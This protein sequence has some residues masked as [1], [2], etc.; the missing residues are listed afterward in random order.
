LNA[1]TLLALFDSVYLVCVSAW[2]GSALFVT[3]GLAPIIFKVLGPEPAARFV[4][5]LFPRYYA[6]CATAGSIALASF[7]TGTLSVPELRGPRVGVQMAL[8]L[9]GT[10]IML[11]CGNSLT[12][13]IDAAR[14]LG[15]SGQPQFDRL[16]RRSVWLNGLV[17]A[18]GVILLAAFATRPSPTTPGIVEL[19]PVERA[20]RDEEQYESVLEKAHAPAPGSPSESPAP[21]GPAGR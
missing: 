9:A 12:P 3:F 21:G 14:D 1:R 5:V 17:L 20:L 2:L 11:Y 8:L 16:H 18:F 19:P 4:R 7:V 10:L 13:A 6:W 15:P